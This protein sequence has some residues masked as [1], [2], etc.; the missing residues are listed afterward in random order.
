MN[1]ET[2][3][4]YKKVSLTPKS[5]QQINQ[6]Q[7]DD[8]NLD[9]NSARKRVEDNLIPCGYGLLRKFGYVLASYKKS[10]TESRINGYMVVSKNAEQDKTKEIRILLEYPSFIRVYYRRVQDSAVIFYIYQI[11]PGG[12]RI[13]IDKSTRAKRI[14]L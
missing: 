7:E 3:Y 11:E 4:I 6:V 8:Q 14:N 2:A 13:L 5:E 9:D 10:G 12:R 1:L